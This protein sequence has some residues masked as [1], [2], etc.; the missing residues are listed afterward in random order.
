[1]PDGYRSVFANNELFLTRSTVEVPLRPDGQYNRVV[2]I[3]FARLHNIKHHGDV[4]EI[5]AVITRRFQSSPCSQY[6]GFSQRDIALTLRGE[7]ELLF[8]T[9]VFRQLSLSTFGWVQGQLR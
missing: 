2:V 4:P 6:P 9:R 8:F 5:P 3:I 1:L 7:V